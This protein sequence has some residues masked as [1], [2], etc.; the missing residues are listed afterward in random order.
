MINQSFSDVKEGVRLINSR[1]PTVINFSKVFKW[2]F[3]GIVIT[4]DVNQKI[5][6]RHVPEHNS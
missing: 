5:S 3:L 1:H 6:E 4:S 2:L